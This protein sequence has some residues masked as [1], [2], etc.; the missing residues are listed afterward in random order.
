MEN[1][2][3]LRPSAARPTPSSTE[4]TAAPTTP[5][6]AICATIF[7]QKGCCVATIA[8]FLAD[9]ENDPTG[10]KTLKAVLRPGRHGQ[11]PAGMGGVRAEAEIL[12]E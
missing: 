4:K 5:R 9:R 10:Y 12:A 3:P 6:P 2:L 7:R 1:C 11:I 8:S